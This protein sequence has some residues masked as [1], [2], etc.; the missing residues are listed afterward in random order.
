MLPRSPETVYRPCARVPEGNALAES[1]IGLFET[2]VIE[3]RGPLA[4]ARRGRVRERWRGVDWFNMRSLLGP[5]GHVPPPAEFQ[6]Q[7]YQLAAVADS[8]NP[9][10]ELPGTLDH[11][12]RAERYAVPPPVLDGC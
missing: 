11:A 1:V 7:Y 9:V 8:T 2:E 4:E 5:I 10:S 6:A 12:L 3:R